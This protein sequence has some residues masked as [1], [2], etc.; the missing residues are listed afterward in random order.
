[1][2]DLYYEPDPGRLN[3]R[4]TLERLTQTPDGQG[5]TVDTY[6]AVGT[7]WMGIEPLRGA[8]LFNA[9]KLKSAVWHKIE[10]RNIGTILPSDRITIGSRHL[11]IESLYSTNQQSATFT[12]FATERVDEAEGDAVT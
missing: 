12:I 7:Y 4:G 1:M 10:M 5:G 9:L 2:I 8:A 3:N 6:A 11:Y